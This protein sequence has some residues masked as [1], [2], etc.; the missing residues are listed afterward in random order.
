VTAVLL[1]EHRALRLAAV[2]LAV[3][4]DA[5]DDAPHHAGIER[6]AREVLEAADLVYA[7]LT[8][9]APPVSITLTAGPITDQPTG[10]VTPTD[11]GAD[12]A[13]ELG[14]SQQVTI[15]ATPKDAAGQPTTDTVAWA[16]DNPAAVKPLQVSADTLEVTLLGAVPAA[17]V[18]L[19][20]T[21]ASGNS[22]PFVF[23]VVPGAAT[24]L[25]LT[26]GPVTD[27]PA[28]AA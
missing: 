15:T 21:D 25:G 24:S 6:R 7:W 22:A 13:L 19:T 10:A 27:Q 18:T 20:A 26:A 11:T 17:G 14:D 4:I 1:N 9:P 2:E 3:H 16:V 12:M 23:D 8:Q 28:P 5:N